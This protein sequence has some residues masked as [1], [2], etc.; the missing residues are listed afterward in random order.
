MRYSGPRKLDH[1]LSYSGLGFKPGTV[2]DSLLLSHLLYG[3]RK[4]KGFHSLGPPR[5]DTLPGADLWNWSS[6]EQVKEVFVAPPG[7]VLLKGDYSP[8][9]MPPQ[10][11]RSLLIRWNSPGCC[12]RGP[13]ISSV[14][15]GGCALSC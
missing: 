7:R 5:P 1:Q 13:V 10:E 3:T 8:A 9:T 15:P 14:P 12:S 4:G 2:H 6:P 11:Q